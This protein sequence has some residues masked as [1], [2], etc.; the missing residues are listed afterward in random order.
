VAGF[1]C[2]SKVPLTKYLPC[3]TVSTAT[4]N[5]FG[6]APSSPGIQVLSDGNFPN[7]YSTLQCTRSQTSK[8]TGRL[9]DSQPCC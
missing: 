1:S 5:S 4:S 9:A 2:P 7:D 8:P 3:T 6:I